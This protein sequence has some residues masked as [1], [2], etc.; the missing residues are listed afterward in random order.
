MTD[1]NDDYLDLTSTTPSDV[2]KQRKAPA[3]GYLLRVQ[4]YTKDS[5][6]GGKEYFEV[7][8]RIME[9]LEGQDLK[10]ARR[11]VSKRFYFNKYGARDLNALCFA[12]NPDWKEAEEKFPDMLEQSVGQN[13]LGTLSY[14]QKGEKEYTDVKG[15]KKAS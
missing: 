1:V 3:G 10:D 6:E 4:S 15:F 13:V 9:A 7:N 12:V 14:Q 8:F 5:S 11:F 2:P